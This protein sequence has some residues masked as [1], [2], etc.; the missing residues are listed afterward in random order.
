MGLGSPVMCMSASLTEMGRSGSTVCIEPSSIT[1]PTF[2]PFH[3]GMKR[4]T[5]SVSRNAPRS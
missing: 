5:G 4:S 2:R 3:D 1:L